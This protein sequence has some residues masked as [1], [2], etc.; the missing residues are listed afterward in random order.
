MMYFR[1][2]LNR[3]IV[4]CL[5]SF[6]VSCQPVPTKPKQ[7]Y[8]PYEA[9]IRLLAKGLMTKL[10]KR[11]SIFS[12][13][14]S[15]IVLNPF[16]EVDSGQVLQASLEIESLLIEETRQHFNQFKLHRLTPEKLVEAQY[17]LNGIIKYEAHKSSPNEKYYHVSASIV[18]LETKIVITKGTVWIVS[19][20][21]DYQPTPS[22]ED[23]P[24]YIKGKLLTHTLKTVDSPVGTQVSDDYYTFIK[25]KALLIA[26]QT[27]YDKQN[28]G[29][30]RNLFKEVTQR[31]NGQIIEAYGGLYTANFKL[32]DLVEAE[33]SFGE[34]VALAVEKG[35]LPIKLLFQ[36]NLIE[37]LEVPNL[38]EQYTLWLRQISLYFKKETGKC[39]TII[40][41]SSQ[42]GDY[43]Y[44]KKLSQ[45]R[46]DKIQIL[47]QEEFSEIKQRANTIGMGS[48]ETIVG[49][50]PD[51]AENAIDRRV[52]FQITDC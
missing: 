29:L 16:L 2:S 27:A 30:A 9:G 20:G 7:A 38:R 24:L 31:Q 46:A 14:T 10:Q 11:Q 37:F 39:V 33:E 36:S 42:S 23:N 41:H 47:L 25:T 8:F 12:R 49:T 6:L 15:T 32:K 19:A 28:Y 3:F 48:D 13:K 26:A 44:N 50:V 35:V 43:K 5:I 4:F 22:Y 52:E 17:I 51:S 45:K 40:G 34:M 1:N 21:L 18:D